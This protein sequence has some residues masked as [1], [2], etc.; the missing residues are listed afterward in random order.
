MSCQSA[1]ALLPA[2]LCSF[3]L[4]PRFISDI[5]SYYQGRTD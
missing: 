3:S 1:P 2:Y 5:C 4:V